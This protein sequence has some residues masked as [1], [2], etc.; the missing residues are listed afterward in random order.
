MEP[1]LDVTIA[2]AVPVVPARY[3]RSAQTNP[4]DVGLEVAMLKSALLYADHLVLASWRVSL[5][6]AWAAVKDGRERGDARQVVRLLGAVEYATSKDPPPQLAALT[7]I[8]A[9]ELTL[10]NVEAAAGDRLQLVDFLLDAA[11]NQPS[12][13]EL[14]TAMEAGV[15]DIKEMGSQTGFGFAKEAAIAEYL[16]LITELTSPENRAVPMLD[17]SAAGVLEVGREVGLLKSPLPRSSTELG[18]VSHYVGYLPAFPAATMESVLHARQELNPTLVGFRSAMVALAAGVAS[19]PT[20]AAFVPE[21]DEVFRKDVAPELAQLA[22]ITDERRLLPSI[23]DEVTGAHGG[24][25]TKAVIG[26]AAAGA[27]GWPQIAQAAV[28]A[29]VVAGDVASG[30]FQRLRDLDTARQSNKLL[31]LYELNRRFPPTD[32]VE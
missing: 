21:A 2:A 7:E 3:G 4:L 27:A 31:W 14:R 11:L 25:I 28:G 15:V 10:S 5:V 30:V 18:L 19:S 1:L 22:R 17:Y 20:D 23:R 8:P 6:E 32:A 12:W 16:G 9:D 29:A 24:T 26:L 13:R